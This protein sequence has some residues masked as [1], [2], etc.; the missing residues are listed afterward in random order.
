MDS[1]PGGCGSVAAAGKFA[2][3]SLFLRALG[4]AGVQQFRYVLFSFPGRRFGHALIY[5]AFEERNTTGS[6]LERDVK[7]GLLTIEL[8]D[9]TK[10]APIRSTKSTLS[11]MLGS[12]FSR[13]ANYRY[14]A[15]HS[16]WTGNQ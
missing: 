11:I 14:G 3:L 8:L 10:D 12:P 2:D 15:F 13:P 9:R 7:A 1:T 6:L 5:T 16:S 4:C